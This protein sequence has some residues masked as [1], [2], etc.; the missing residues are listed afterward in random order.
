MRRRRGQVHRGERRL[1]RFTAKWR[2]IMTRDRGSVICFLLLWFDIYRVR[3]STSSVPAIGL[4]RRSGG[5]AGR[6]EAAYLDE[7][8]YEILRQP[9]LGILL[10][11]EVL[12]HM[13]ELLP[14]V[15]SLLWPPISTACPRIFRCR[16][17]MAERT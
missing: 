4:A 7:A 14:K 16:P 8:L 10:R 1:R 5:T 11:S 6:G 9:R 3:S 13:C 17:G 15:Q 2:G 12:Q